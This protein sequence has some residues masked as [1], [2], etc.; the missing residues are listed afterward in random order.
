M[1]RIL[2]AIALLSIATPALADSAVKAPADPNKVRCKRETVTG[3]LVASAKVCHTEAEWH[4]MAVRAREDTI[5]M[6]GV[7]NSNKG[8][9]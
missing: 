3:S 4:E 6:Q 9:N 5:R 1:I 2:S 7:Q 8:G